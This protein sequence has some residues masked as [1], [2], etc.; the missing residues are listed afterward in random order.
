MG[1]LKQASCRQASGPRPPLTGSRPSDVSTLWAS[2]SST[3][4]LRNKTRG[5]QRATTL[6]APEASAEG[7]G[8]FFSSDISNSSICT[9]RKTICF[10]RVLFLMSGN[11]QIGLKMISPSDSV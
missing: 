5:L 7:L 9:H 3:V 4:S 11:H 6:V 1:K 8:P 2:V 10:S